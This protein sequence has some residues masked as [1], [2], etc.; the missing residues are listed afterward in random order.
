MPD[1]QYKDLAQA[2]RLSDFVK[3]ARYEPVEVDKANSWQALRNAIQ[4][5][6]EMN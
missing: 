1:A 4:Q 5:L 6:E 3:F 2:L